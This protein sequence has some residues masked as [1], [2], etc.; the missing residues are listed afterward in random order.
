[1]EIPYWSVLFSPSHNV[2]SFLCHIVFGI[3]LYNNVWNVTQYVLSSLFSR[4]DLTVWLAS[5]TRLST[6]N[7]SH[8]PPR[9]GRK[10]L[11]RVSTLL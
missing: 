6:M 1:M 2:S 3:S 10:G 9:A 7:S 5:V 4:W 8:T 11:L